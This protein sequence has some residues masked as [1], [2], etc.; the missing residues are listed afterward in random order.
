M[1]G[2]EIL[3]LALEEGVKVLPRNFLKDNDIKA[4]CLGR[5]AKNKSLSM[6]GYMVYLIEEEGEFKDKVVYTL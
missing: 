5:S 4:K 2:I 6:D 1:S 3:K